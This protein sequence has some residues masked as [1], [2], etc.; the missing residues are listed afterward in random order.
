MQG[1]NCANFGCPGSKNHFGLSIFR[2]ATKDDEYS[3]NWRQKSATVVS[4]PPPPLFIYKIDY[5]R[6]FYA[7]FEKY[8]NIDLKIIGKCSNSTSKFKVSY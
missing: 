8:K 5:N 6:I 1:T 2:I 7:D 4:S 3:I